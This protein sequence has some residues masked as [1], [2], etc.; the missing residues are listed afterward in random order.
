MLDSIFLIDNNYEKGEV[1]L[2]IDKLINSDVFSDVDSI[3][4]VCAT[5]AEFCLYGCSNSNCSTCSHSCSPGC[6][7]SSCSNRCSAD[8]SSACVTG[9]T[10]NGVKTCVIAC[11]VGGM[12][13]VSSF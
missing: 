4:N 1:S 10:V 13:D 2:D 7:D 9:C 5:C 8:C 6:S 3:L 11:A 12:M